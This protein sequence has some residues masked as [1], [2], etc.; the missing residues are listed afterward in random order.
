MS[1]PQRYCGKGADRYKI[2]RLNPN[3]PLRVY[4]WLCYDHANDVAKQGYIVNKVV[5]EL[6]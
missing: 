6:P 1:S 4:M 5:P 2:E 3:Q